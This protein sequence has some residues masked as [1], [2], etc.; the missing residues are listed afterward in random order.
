MIQRLRESKLLRL[1]SSSV[2]DQA[3]LS[4]ASFAVGLLLLRNTSNEHY[5]LY[6]LAQSAMLLAVSLHGAFVG[7]PLSILASKKTDALRNQMI[8]AVDG[9]L[10]RLLL[11]TVL[12][13]LPIPALLWMAN[14]LDTLEV[15]VAT[16]ALIACWAS[17]RRDYSRTVLLMQ[18]QPNTILRSDLAFVAVLVAG[19]AIASLGPLASVA[20]A[21][22]VVGATAAAFVGDRLGRAAVRRSIGWQPGPAAGWWREM[23][24]LS[25]WASVGALTHFSLSQSYNVIVASQFDV[26]AVAAVNA[27]RLM[28]MPTYLLANGVKGLLVPMSARWLRDEGFDALLR[29]LTLFVIGLGVLSLAYFV[30][31]WFSRD[32]IMESVLKK[33]FPQ[34]DMMICGWGVLVLI[35]L[36]R[37]TYQNALLVREKF[38]ALAGLVALGATVSIGSMWVAIDHFGTAGVVLGMICGELVYLFCVIAL[39]LRERAKPETFGAAAETTPNAE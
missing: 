15:L 9:Y 20:A 1:F 31:M 38:R 11:I 13:L 34:M 23:L 8:G 3:L 32:W 5:G 37:D 26:A 33:S 28:L 16:A 25:T 7:G 2:I 21:V 30:V 12:L 24:P 29:K 35:N 10:H 36:V 22:A 14:V 17:M 6:V 18:A 27:A 39:V 4:G 19:A